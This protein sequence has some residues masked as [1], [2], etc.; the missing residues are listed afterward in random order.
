MRPDQ[1]RSSAI[2]DWLNGLEGR[3]ALAVLG[4]DVFGPPEGR[5]VLMLHPWQLQ[6]AAD[7]ITSSSDFGASWRSAGSPMVAWEHLSQQRGSSRW[8][9]AWYE[10]GYRSLV[11]V[12]VPLP[13]LRG[14]ECFLFTEELLASAADAH[15]L[16][17][18]IMS[19]W[20]TLREEIRS[21]SSTLL[22]ERERMCLSLAFEGLTAAETAERMQI[23]ER[24]VTATMQQAMEKLQAPN[25]I[26]A[27][28]RACWLGA[29]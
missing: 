16:T 1:L 10:H 6:S 8:R 22:T 5:K 25:K 11:R 3:H 27:I 21:L 26:A 9:A 18:A 15:R 4:P 2:E 23:P 19:M 13:G 17:G 29:I 14:F 12:D 24:R 7:A 20:A 28:Q